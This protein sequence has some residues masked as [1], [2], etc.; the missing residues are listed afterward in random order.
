VT[1]AAAYPATAW[2]YDVQ[3]NFD[4]SAPGHATVSGHRIGRYAVTWAGNVTTLCPGVH[5]GPFDPLGY[6]DLPTGD[7]PA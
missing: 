3:M 7:C 6:V 2:L 5:A 1:V 4:V